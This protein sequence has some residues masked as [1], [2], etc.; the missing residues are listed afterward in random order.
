M[1]W[2]VDRLIFENRETVE[3]RLNIRSDSGWEIYKIHFDKT[4]GGHDRVTIIS[5]KR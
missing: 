1:K 4:P 2:K 3:A 5:T